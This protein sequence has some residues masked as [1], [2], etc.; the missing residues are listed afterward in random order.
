MPSARSW[1]SFSP[2]AWPTTWGQRTMVVALATLVVSILVFLL[3]TGAWALC[4]ARLV[5]GIAVGLLTSSAG[6][7]LGDLHRDRSHQVAAAAN[8]AATSTGIA[9]G[10]VLSGLAVQFAPAPLVTPF[11]VLAVLS[12]GGLVLVRAIPAWQIVPARLR[13]W[14]PR[15]LRMGAESRRVLLL[16]GPL[17]TAGWAVVGMYLALGVDLVAS[18]LHTSNRALSSL[19][20][21]VVQGCG[22]I[23]PMLLRRLDDRAASVTG[24]ALLTAGLGVLRHR[25]RC[26]VLLRCRG[27]RR[28][29]RPFLHG[30]LEHRDGGGDHRGPLPAPA[31]VFRLGLS[32]GECA[33]GRP[34]RRCPPLRSRCRLLVVQPAGGTARRDR[35][36]HR[37]PPGRMLVP[38]G[39]GAL[40]TVKRGKCRLTAVP[41]EFATS[42]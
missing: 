3:A 28:G 10:A 35:G 9:L 2:A 29:L 19:V 17:V 32:G 5:Q 21:L 33:G 41:T 27:H 14:R 30:L 26:P 37:C 7:A 34:G 13:P 16:V 40:P 25:S 11:V 8:S 23:A 38:G 18:L 31:G 36:S 24:C 1:P 39:E 6:S 12:V 42:N 4:L 20:I 15:V 22:G